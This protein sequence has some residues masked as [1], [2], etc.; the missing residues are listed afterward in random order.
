MPSCLVPK[1]LLPIQP[2]VNVHLLLCENVILGYGKFLINKIG[3]SHKNL[4]WVTWAEVQNIEGFV[5]SAKNFGLHSGK[6]AC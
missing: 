2:N 5:H 4:I 3:S 1:T 6:N